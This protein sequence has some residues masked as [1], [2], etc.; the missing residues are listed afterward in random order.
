MDK[1]DEVL[2]SFCNI[3]KLEEAKNQNLYK[4]KSTNTSWVFLNNN[5]VCTQKVL[6]RLIVSKKVLLNTF[7][8]CLFRLAS[9]KQTWVYTSNISIIQIAST[10]RPIYTTVLY[11]VKYCLH[12]VQFTSQVFTVTESRLK[13]HRSKCALLIQVFWSD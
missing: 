12:I 4:I 1:I 7:V 3:I 5:Y 13:T 10:S 6:I 11:A 9:A 8:Y 2:S